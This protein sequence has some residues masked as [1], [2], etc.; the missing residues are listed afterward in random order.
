LVTIQEV[1]KKSFFSPH[2]AFNHILFPLSSNLCEMG[3]SE[4]HSL[5]PSLYY[6]PAYTNH[7]VTSFFC[8]SCCQTNANFFDFVLSVLCPKVS[9][10]I[11]SFISMLQATQSF[12][13]RYLRLLFSYPT[14][15]NLFA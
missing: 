12:F 13:L 7:L 4:R 15:T 9:V 1:K 2:S 11:Y 5:F 3:W 6:C 10:A 8:S 14:L